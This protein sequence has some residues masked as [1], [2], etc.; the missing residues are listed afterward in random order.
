MELV[1]ALGI[2]ALLGI[3]ISGI[4]LFTTGSYQK[5]NVESALQQEAQFT[6]NRINGLIMDATDVVEYGFFADGEMVPAVNEEKAVENGAI[7]GADRYLKIHNAR[8]IYMIQYDAAAKK[9]LYWEENRETLAQTQKEP[10]AEGI[11]GFEADTTAFA[12]SKSVQLKLIVE[13]EGKRISS[14]Y[15]MS[16]RNGSPITVTEETGEKSATILV[17]SQVVVEPKQ[18]FFIPV[19]VTGFGIKNSGFH[20]LPIEED[21]KDEETLIQSTAEGIRI[22]PGRNET[23]GDDRQIYLA[24]ETVEKDNNG[25]ALDTAVI[26]VKIR[27]VLSV[28]VSAQAVAGTPAATAHT[29]FLQG[30]KYKFFGVAD[31]QHMDQMLTD[32]YDLDYKNPY[33]L[34]WNICFEKDGVR[35]EENSSE[36]GNRFQVVNRV[37]NYGEPYCEIMLKQDMPKDSKLIVT[38]VSKHVAGTLDGEVYNKSG[39]SYGEI[40]SYA[41]LVSTMS[42][43]V[44]YITSTISR[45]AD[46]FFDTTLNVTALKSQYAPEDGNAQFY[47]LYRMREKADD[48][49]LGAWT[50]YRNMQQGGSDKKLNANESCRFLPDRSYQFEIIGTVINRSTSTLYWPCDTS[51]FEAGTGLSGFNKGFGDDAPATAKD[52]YGTIHEMPKTAISFMGN[53]SYSIAD[54][55]PSYG[56]EDN[57]VRVT[58]GDSLHVEFGIP[59]GIKL[60][61]FKAHMKSVVEKKNGSGWEDVSIQLQQGG[62]YHLDNLQNY[63]TGLYRIGVVLEDAYF[64]GDSTGLWDSE[65]SVISGVDMNLYNFDTDAGTIYFEIY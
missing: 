21:T 28:E 48:G 50:E 8:I 59:I 37:E 65:Y 55:S 11:E 58:V 3:T 14:N 49:T 36:F 20:L 12:D 27:R 9:L 23:G 52:E 61:S 47:W 34:K 15:M 41:E 17:E 51:L 35:Y 13:K 19:S 25:V 45:G 62:V 29:A 63:P 38:A 44:V 10:L 39:E 2:L 42:Q 32:A 46:I 31:G 56:T 24:L 22:R 7:E 4:L 53:A 16:A 43:E 57:H 54:N 60:D 1:C 33:Y 64:L 18:D 5:G 40:K 6:A 30:A 26:S